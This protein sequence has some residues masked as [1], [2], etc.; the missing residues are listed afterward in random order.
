MCIYV[1]NDI[2]LIGKHSLNCLKANRKAR[3]DRARRRKQYIMELNFLQALFG[4]NCLLPRALKINAPINNYFLPHTLP[5][6]TVPGRA[7]KEPTHCSNPW[8]HPPVG[9]KKMW[10]HFL[11][12]PNSKNRMAHS[13]QMPRVGSPLASPG[14]N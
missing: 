1:F 6:M 10:L 2:H 12:N 7:A 11:V 13:Q 9:C 8:P 5:N 14:I 4:F 3:R